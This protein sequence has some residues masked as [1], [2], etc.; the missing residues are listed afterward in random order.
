MKRRMYQ[1]IDCDD[2]REEEEGRSNEPGATI[3]IGQ[4]N[5]SGKQIG[6]ERPRKTFMS[7]VRLDPFLLGARFAPLADRS[8]QNRSHRGLI[9]LSQCQDSTAREEGSV[10]LERITMPYISCVGGEEEGRKKRKSLL[11]ENEGFSVVAPISWM[12]P[13]STAGRKT[14]SWDLEKR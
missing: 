13:L 9:K 11:T 8:L 2:E 6:I 14:S 3:S 12:T 4:R 7:R 10:D 5:E 1:C